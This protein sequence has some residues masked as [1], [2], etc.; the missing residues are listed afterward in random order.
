[1]EA[2]EKELAE[3]SDVGMLSP[4]SERTTLYFETINDG[5]VIFCRSGF[6]AIVDTMKMR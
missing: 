6:Y 4:H 1:V 5:R 2:N 3:R